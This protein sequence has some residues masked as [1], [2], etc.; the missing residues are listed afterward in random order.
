M[1]G[2]TDKT[3]AIFQSWRHNIIVLDQ[4]ALLGLYSK[5]NILHISS[6]ILLDMPKRNKLGVFHA[7]QT[8]MCLD[9]HLN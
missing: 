5:H 9:P 1:K 6:S 4:T 8:S 2:W 7:N 3:R